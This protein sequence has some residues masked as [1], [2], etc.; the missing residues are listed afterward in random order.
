MPFLLISTVVSNLV[1][2]EYAR[3]FKKR[4]PRGFRQSI[5]SMCKGLEYCTIEY[6]YLQPQDLLKLASP[7]NHI[8][9]T[10]LDFSKCQLTLAKPKIVIILH[11]DR[12][13]QS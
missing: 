10:D 13:C 2:F 9:I 4:P 5:I 6:E 3:I 7:K 12:P 11:N 1:L 8:Y